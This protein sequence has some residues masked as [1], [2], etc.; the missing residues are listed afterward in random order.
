[1]SV[2]KFNQSTKEIE[3]AGT[4]SFIESNFNEIRNLLDEHFGVKK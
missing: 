4:E 2:I 1:M 3:M